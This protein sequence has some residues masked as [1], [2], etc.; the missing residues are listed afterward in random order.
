MDF[1]GD[2]VVFPIRPNAIYEMLLFSKN[3]TSLYE[4]VIV[5]NFNSLTFAQKG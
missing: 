4:E 1:N 3:Q 2:Q 5:T